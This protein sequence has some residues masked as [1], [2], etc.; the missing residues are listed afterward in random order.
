MRQQPTIEHLIIMG[1][2]LS[3]RG[4]MD[5]RKL[6]GF[7][8]MDALSGLKGESAKGRFTNGYVWSDYVSSMIANHLI[9]GALESHGQKP[10]DIADALI[11]GDKKLEK[12]LTEDD[13]LDS[14]RFVHFNGQDFMRS[15]D[16]GGL[17][18][19]SYRGK[20]S[21]NIPRL[22]TA[23]ILSTLADQRAKLLKD[24]K[25]RGLTKHHK[26]RTLL[27][28]WSGAN[29]LITINKKLTIAEADRAVLSRLQNVE[30]LMQN[31]YPHF[32]LFNL[33]D[34][35]LTPRFQAKSKAEQDNAHRCVTHFNQELKEKGDALGKKLRELDPNSSLD[36]FDINATFTAAYQTPEKYHLDPK[37]R[38]T[39]YIKSDDF[40]ITKEH[41]SP[42]KG[43]IFWDDVHPT[44]AVH[45]LL[46][47]KFYMKFSLLY[48]FAAPHDTL[49][50]QFRAVYGDT[51]GH[52]SAK[53]HGLFHH[54]AE[55]SDYRKASLEQVFEHALHK[56]G[57]HTQEVLVHLEWINKTGE[58]ISRH[59]ALLKAFHAVE[60]MNTM[61]KTL[62]TELK[63]AQ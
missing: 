63:I 35:S 10:E 47:E 8:P 32:V 16:E 54:K 3:D 19:Y 38:H 13:Q 50:E 14:D 5:K 1:D 9:I 21:I 28:E 44:T 45:A 33:P 62:E 36:V 7:I 57:K 43:Y 60:A 30:A 40:K 29:D 56:G 41:T 48:K 22:V 11:T 25:K 37:K 6:L 4:T 61:E 20:R 2:S 18:S 49:I 58:L 26:A 24:D 55:F 17:T 53:H 12:T 23:E 34:L 27:I 52:A 39:P 46:A 31:G 15:Y 59:P 51:V 42:A